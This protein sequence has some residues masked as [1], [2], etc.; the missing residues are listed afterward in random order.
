MGEMTIFRKH[1]YLIIPAVAIITILAVAPAVAVPLFYP[2]GS[3]DHPWLKTADYEN[4]NWAIGLHK[5]N[6]LWLAV[7][8]GGSFGIGFAGSQI[9]PE[10]GER[11]P[12]CEYPAG[13]DVSYLYIAAFWAGAVVGRDT[14][15]ST[16]FEGNSFIK[17]FWPGAG[18]DGGIIRRSN[19]KTSLDYSPDAVSEQDFICSFTD[20][21]TA[22]G[23]T[24]IDAFDNRPH[25]PLGLKVT[26]R[27][28]A[29][30]YDYAEDFILFDY[31]IQNINRFPLK[32]IYFGLYVDA[33]V[34]HESRRST[35]GWA[36]DICGYLNSIPAAEAPGY[37]DTVRVA[38]T[39]DADGDPNGAA[40]YMFD[41]TSATALTGTAVLRTPNPDLQFS[42][43][44][45]IASG[46]ASRDW[47]PRKAGTD[48]FPYRDFGTGMGSPNGDRNKYYMMSTP[49][50]DYD[51][52]ESA[53][54]HT[55]EGWLPPPRNAD[56]FADGYDARYLF[57]FGPFDLQPG[58]TLPITLAYVAGADFH[59]KGP[60]FK[61]Y[62]DPLNPG[63]Y[64]SRLSYAS[65][66]KNAKWARW[67]FDNPGYDTN[68]DFDSGLARWV[69]DSLT[70][71]S[72][73]YF[74]A[75]DGV[76]DFRGASPP[77]PPVLKV[78][79]E[80]G[81]LILNWNG[82]VSEENID[83]FSDEKDFEGYRVYYGMDNR[84]SDYVMLSSYDRDNYNVYI[85]DNILQ[86]WDFSDVPVSTDSLRIMF[87]QDFDPSQYDTP[88]R[89]VEKD[90][91][92]YYFSRQDWNASNLTDPY[93]IH[94]LYPDADPNDP[95]DTT[96]DGY[97]RY[98]EYEYIIEGLQPSQP[99]YVAVTAFDY[100]SRKI[101]LSSLESSPNLNAILAYPLTATED[102][103]ERGMDVK[104]YPNP[105][106][107]DG[108]YAGSG[109]ENRDRTKSA[110]RGRSVHFFNLPKVCTI[111]I[112]T[113]DGDLVQQIDHNRP[114]AGADAQHERWDL[115]SRN[116]QAVVTGIYLYH[117]TSDM[118]EQIGK[119][120]IMK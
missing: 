13:S 78:N 110:E 71:D 60:D 17:E 97:H 1:A 22:T 41:Y 38:W 99:Y 117:V 39:A 89:T 31:T 12:S 43:N 49:E 47:G 4:P 53:I 33:D 15:V 109:Y 77:P 107:V 103:E 56:D 86:R 114:D 30:S 92:F 112:Y 90:G 11:A 57:S 100:G 48:E 106:R 44:W 93:G 69:V 46:D 50:F 14:L 116:T 64:Q 54:S 62:W 108:G 9:D 29:W 32:Q 75:G 51:Q 42:Y 72:S 61:T 40:G 67:V 18:S 88:G 36:D 80:F 83:V 23:L 94:R 96:E 82:Q 7:T 102:V 87:G 95:T 76:P 63:L 65:L 34:F 58:D 113:I 66:G 120:V 79:P 52:L 10:T 59:Q 85:W 55:G 8:N 81:R 24:G 25:I 21:F 91:I 104:V 3:G 37:E 101:S 98:Y 70:M 73:R 68:N 6:N 16:G 28:Y 2:E 26:Q 84:L 27:S 5:I 111:R 19:M 35:S 74:Y 20:T 118:G 45:W 115:I 119:L 105:Y